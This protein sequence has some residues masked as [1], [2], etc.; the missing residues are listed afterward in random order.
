MSNSEQYCSTVEL[1]HLTLVGGTWN[2]IATQGYDFSLVELVVELNRDKV[3]NDRELLVPHAAASP[4]STEA[5]AGSPLAPSAPGEE[6]EEE[7]NV[8]K[9]PAVVS[10]E[11]ERPEPVSASSGSCCL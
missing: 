6:A 5:T 3:R 11:P 7:Q 1:A 10:R 2:P 9:S 8:L 4:Q